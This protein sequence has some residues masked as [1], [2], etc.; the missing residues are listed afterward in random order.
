MEGPHPIERMLQDSVGDP[1]GD[2][3]GHMRLVGKTLE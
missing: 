3:F 1:F 2:P